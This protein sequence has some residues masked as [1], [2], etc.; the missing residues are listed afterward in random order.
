MMKFCSAPFMGLYIKAG[1]NKVKVAPCCEIDHNDSPWLDL[2]EDLWNSSWLTN[3]RNQHANKKMPKECS[4]CIKREESGGVSMR[5]YYNELFSETNT[6]GPVH[7]DFQPNNFCNLKCRMCGPNNSNLIAKEVKNNPGYSFVKLKAEDWQLD[8]TDRFENKIFDK[9]DFTQ[10]KKIKYLGGEPFVQD[11][12][13]EF[14]SRIP[15]K[16]EIELHITSNLTRLPDYFLDSV[17]DFKNVNVNASIDGINDVYEYVRTNGKW[18][19]VKTN[20]KKLLE[21][22]QE[23][24]L[25]VG[26]SFCL[27]MYNVFNLKE[28]CIEYLNEFSEYEHQPITWTHVYQDYLNVKLL[29][30]LHTT[31][32]IEDIN[33]IM[34]HSLLN[35]DSLKGII[36]NN[37]AKS[38]KEQFVAHTAI[39]DRIRKT[40]LVS[41]DKRFAKYVR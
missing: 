11:Y 19:V 12:F 14:L 8:V 41:L 35:L 7:V 6:T 31:Q 2:D 30:K 27:Q 4:W 9:I 17:N 32:V 34:N 18:E 39:Q 37:T 1:N 29:S 26:L 28:F 10:V 15:N 22:S 33:S 40:N 13:K 5:Q 36:T 21:F 20:Y 38:N 3:I 24:N 16:K 23:N 25:T